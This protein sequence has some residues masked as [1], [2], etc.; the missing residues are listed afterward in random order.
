MATCPECERHFD[1]GVEACPDDGAQLLP[2]DVFK[3][4]DTLAP[5]T[6]L[7]EYEVGKLLGSG[8]FG[9][10]YAGEQPLIGK[11]VAIKVLNRRFTADAQVVS[12]FIAE[13]RAVNRIRHRN[14]IDI[15]SFGTHEEQPYFVMEL[16][17]GETLGELIDKRGAIPFPEAWPI[18]EGV[19][20]AL[21]AAHAAEIT[22]RDLKPDNIFVARDRKGPRYAKLLDFGIAKLAGPD[23]SHKTATGYAIGTPRYMSPEQARGRKVD[24]RADIY[25]LGVVVHEMLVGEPPFDGE[26]AMDM[27]FAHTAEPAPP[28]SRQKEGLPEALDQPVL[29]MLEKRPQKRPTSAGEAVHALLEAAVSAGIMAAPSSSE[30]ATDRRLGAATMP[31]VVSRSEPRPSSLGPSTRSVTGTDATVLSDDSVSLPRPSTGAVTVRESSLPAPTTT[32]T[33]T[34]VSVAATV[35]QRPSL[36]G[37]APEDARPTDPGST[38]RSVGVPDPPSTEAP[39]GPGDTVRSP[40]ALPPASDGRAARDDETAAPVVSAASD[41]MSMRDGAP[42]SA[43]QAPA[44]KMP[45]AMAAVALGALAVAG[46]A[47]SRGGASNPS[48][49]AAATS[50]TVPSSGTVT[51]ELDVTPAD[52]R[53]LVDGR[54]M[55][56][57]QSPLVLPKSDTAREVRFDKA[58]HTM[59]VVTVVPNRDQ[60]LPAITL[61]AQATTATAPAPEPVKPLPAVNP[62]PGGDHPDIQR[63]DGL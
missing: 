21:D 4:S 28:M 40:V 36:V 19:A 60:S 32:E 24:H 49:P 27:L 53:V 15:F 48:P 35:Q 47:I 7:G 14:I 23:K 39:I 6:M 12:R 61:A 52:A 37:E 41:T 46:L 58:G 2:D 11:Q 33:A 56:T 13:A 3:P 10:V 51:I 20:D 62:K 63:P 16:L 26:T 8:T 50:A 25:A 38:K 29:A 31:N 54:E 1:D 57:A 59:Q 42:P 17:E 9:D 18:I 55:G 44:S 22:H 30:R 34:P 43:T 5:G 45:L